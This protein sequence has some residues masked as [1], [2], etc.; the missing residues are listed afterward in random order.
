MI[1]I[2]QRNVSKEELKEMLY[3]SLNY[4]DKQLYQQVNESQAN[5]FQ[6]SGRT[7]ADMIRQAI[8][9]NFN[10]MVSINS[11]SRPGSS[12]QLQ[13][14]INNGEEGSKYPEFISKFLKDSHGCIL[15]QEQIMAIATECGL[16]ANYVRGLLKK[17]GKANKKQEDLEKWTNVVEQFK[18][19]FKEK[20]MSDNEI[21]MVIDDFV[22]LSA[23]SFNRSH[24]AAYT[25]VACETL[26]MSRYFKPYFWA[27]SLTYDATKNDVLKDSIKSAQKNGFK[28]LPPDV[29]SSN[30]HFTPI[31]EK[32]IRFGLNEI[33]GVGEEPAKNII[34]LREGGYKS[35][36][37]F[38]IK[39]LG[40]KVNKRITL[41]L[42]GAGAFDDL[43]P[44]GERKK[45]LKITEQF[46]VDKKTSKNPDKLREVWE[47]CVEDHYL[48]GKTS[49]E[50]Y[51]EMEKNY[52]SGSFFHGVFS[53]DMV[54]KIEKLKSLNKCL[55]DFNEI[56]EEDK[57]SAYVF[58]HV[59]DLRCHN[60]KNGK[61]MVFITAE[62]CNGEELT[63]P[64]FAS[65]YEHIKEK[66]LTG[67]YLMKVYPDD[68]GGILFGSRNWVTNP[69]TIRSF[70]IRYQPRGN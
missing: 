2:L 8:P 1:K 27:A 24:A 18:K 45:Y 12:F 48:D 64:C 22:T 59:K 3:S 56:R 23:Y 67:F 26:Y 29:N 52:L 13:S 46:Y 31:S 66:L 41:A 47:K 65:Y 51:M 70:L 42:I 57:A 21:E 49:P 60:Q 14:F 39:T 62:D 11:L 17:L 69:D 25:Y 35:I 55:R 53:D 61:M 33:K 9:Q 34:E 63:I 7:A 6:F 68:N 4:N 50:E 58:V 32:E 38:I 54:A 5:V 44:E 28:I 30:L 43:I 40:T 19:A 36:I 16:D 37:D 10:D 15:F 20:G